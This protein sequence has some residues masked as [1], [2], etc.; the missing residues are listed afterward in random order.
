MV[1]YRVERGFPLGVHVIRFCQ[2]TSVEWN[3]H[4]KSCREYGKYVKR[5]DVSGF[6]SR[7]DVAGEIGSL[8]AITCHGL[9]G[10][11]ALF[12]LFPEHLDISR[13]CRQSRHCSMSFQNIETPQTTPTR[14]TMSQ[15]AEEHCDISKLKRDILMWYENK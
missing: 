1:V 9:Q 7:S 2:E 11:L 6:L 15:S 3:A 5:R 12:C 4:R 14:S 10:E 13:E 8:G